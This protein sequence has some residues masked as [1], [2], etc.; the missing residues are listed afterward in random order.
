MP[1]ATRANLYRRISLVEWTAR[2]GA[3]TA[4]S[5][6]LREGT[7]VAS[8]RARAVA[9]A[10][11]GL[12]LRRRPL[13]GE[14]S[15]YVITPAGL[16]AAGLRRLGLC[17]ISP[18]NSMHMIACAAVAAALE[19]GFPDQFLLSEREL[20][21]AASAA[22]GPPACAR[23][24]NGPLGSTRLHRPDLALCPSDR[25]GGLPV[26]V[27]VELTIKA[28]RRLAQI[29][30]AWSRARNVAGVVYLAP[31]DVQRALERAID[32]VHGRDRIVVVP[33]RALDEALQATQESLVRTIPT[34]A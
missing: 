11:D 30:L 1:K 25:A 18:S 33:L 6:A 27:E 32:R 21:C 4:E 23:L 5:L 2:M 31:P 34:G 8:A 16:R 24:S 15:L 19:G 29:C 7:S 9:A 3:V 17:R 26:A 14:P 28:P 22:G 20:L 13:A 12:L 10:G